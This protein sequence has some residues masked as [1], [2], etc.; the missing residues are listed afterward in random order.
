MDRDFKTSFLSDLHAEIMALGG[1][2]NAHLH[3]D[4]AETLQP[5]LDIMRALGSGS[6][7]ALAIAQ[8]HALIPLIHDSECY[9]PDAL[10]ERVEGCV[11]KM[12]GL[13]TTHA[14]SVV[15]VTTDRVGTS[16]MERLLRIGDRARPRIDFRVGAYSPLGFRDD[17]PD[18]WALIEAA[19][20]QADFLGALPERDDVADYPEHIGFD[21]CCRRIIALARDLNK[22]VHIHVDQKNHSREHQTERVIEIV[23]EA[24]WGHDGAEPRIWLIHVISPSAYDDARFDRLARDLAELNIGVICCPSAAISMRQIRPVAAPTHN[25]I[26]RVLDLLAAGVFVRLGTDNVCDIT[27]PAGTLDLMDEL[28]VLSNAVRYYDP[29]C[30]AYLGAGRRLPAD[31]IDRLKAHL[32]EDRDQCRRAEIA[33]NRAPGS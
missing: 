3:L 5:T 28:F 29:A 20:Q 27:S 22:Q 24:H 4:R 25:S 19:A 8:K 18:R 15:D 31:A 11:M 26:A 17:D 7:S 9:D 12:A 33:Y 32:E 2:F 1:M 10:E 14:H 23:R 16:A 30:L 21:T 6:D 13:G